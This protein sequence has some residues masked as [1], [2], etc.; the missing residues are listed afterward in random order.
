VPYSALDLRRTVAIYTVAGRPRT[1]EATAL[2]NLM[3]STDW[4]KALD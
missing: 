4:S 1:A 2:L 3:R